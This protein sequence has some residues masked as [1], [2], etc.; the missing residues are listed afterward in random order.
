MDNKAYLE[1]IA[2]STKP[3]PA[4]QNP[5]LEKIQN[6]KILLSAAGVIISI[7]V[8]GF[9]FSFLNK[10]NNEERDNIIKLNLRTANVAQTI[11]TFNNKVKSPRLRSIGTALS[12]ALI[13]ANRNLSE[14][15]LS[16]YKQPKQTKPEPKILSS[17]TEYITKLNSKLQDAKL[18][19]TL[20]RNYLQE[21]ILQTNDLILISEKNYTKNKSPVVRS[22]LEKF[23]TNLKH[24][25][26]RIAIF[27]DY[28]R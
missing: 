19:G 18:N 21:I 2:V 28:S 1:Q 11:D 27:N 8:L 12:S 25:K 20:D 15:L 6:P 13:E 10:S 16:I 3:K 24:I 23:I 26:E 17:E 4:N 9:V 22:Y 14:S 7:F 5:L